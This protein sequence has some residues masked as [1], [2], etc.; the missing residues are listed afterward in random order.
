MK[1]RQALIV[2]LVTFGI[3]VATA[4]DSVRVRTEFHDAFK[5]KNW[6][7][8]EAAYGQLQ[9]TFPL[10]AEDPQIR[11]LYAM[12][13]YEQG[14]GRFTEVEPILRSLIENGDNLRVASLLAELC[15]RRGKPENLA[16]ARTILEEATKRGLPSIKVMARK[17]KLFA[18]VMDDHAFVLRLIKAHSFYEVKNLDGVRNPFIEPDLDSDRPPPP[19]SEEVIAKK[20]RLL[21]K[22]LEL[23]DEEIRRLFDREHFELIPIKL[24]QFAKIVAELESLGSGGMLDRWLAKLRER[25]GQWLEIARAVEIRTLVKQGNDLLTSMA[26]SMDDG[27]FDVA[28]RA[29]E[30]LQRLIVT[31]KDTRDDEAERIAAAFESKGGALDRKARKLGLIASLELRITGIVIGR[32][33]GKRS[34]ALVGD[35]IVRLGENLRLNQLRVRVVEIDEGIVTFDYEGL[36]FVRELEERL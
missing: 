12:A 30:S 35:A 7:K 15:A 2:L 8:V 5:S 11:A 34:S 4:D 32:P 26:A 28:H 33:G 14:P 3:S 17:K 1:K 25:K 9:L 20:Q 36:R 22:D 13:L 24:E 18:R 31:L 29:F 23:L 10:E 6:K 21:E 27:S 16:E 19:P